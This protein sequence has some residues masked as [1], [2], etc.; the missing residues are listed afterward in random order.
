MPNEMNRSTVYIKPRTPRE[1]EIIKTQGGV[2]IKKLPTPVQYKEPISS[3][4]LT[5]GVI[6]KKE[7]KPV[8]IVKNSEVKNRESIKSPITS[9]SSFEELQKKVSA[10]REQE[11]NKTREQVGTSEPEVNRVSFDDQ[12]ND[13]EEL[14]SGKITTEQDLIT[15]DYLKSISIIRLKATYEVCTGS[16]PKDISK[17]EI[18]KTILDKYKNSSSGRKK[19]IYESTKED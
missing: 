5:P 17:F 4:V 18:R 7:N 8:Q 11:S 19:V 14:A 2:I 6:Y 16:K 9:S 1:Y 13:M 15:M 10:L 3:D 12:I